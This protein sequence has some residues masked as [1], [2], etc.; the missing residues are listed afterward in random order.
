MGA[1]ADYQREICGTDACGL[2]TGRSSIPAAMTADTV[3]PNGIAIGG[4]A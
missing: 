1:D 3:A 2:S 4:T